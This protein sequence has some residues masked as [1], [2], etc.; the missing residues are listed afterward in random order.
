MVRFFLG[1]LDNIFLRVSYAGNLEGFP[2]CSQD[3]AIHWLD[4]LGMKFKLVKGQQ[5][6]NMMYPRAVTK[7]SA[8]SD[9]R[10]SMPFD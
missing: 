2:R 3:C 7:C 4:Y 8:G 9:R 1:G 10:L 6:G 5:A